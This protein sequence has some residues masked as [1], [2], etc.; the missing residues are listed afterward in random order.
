[1]HLWKLGLLAVVGG[2]SL[3]ER[4]ALPDWEIGNEDTDPVPPDTDIVDTDTG[5]VDT[6]TDVEDTD[7]NDT[8]VDPDA[9]GLTVP[10]NLGWPMR[11]RRMDPTTR[12]PL[13]EPCTVP[14]GTTS[15]TDASIE[16]VVDVNELDVVATGL[17]ID[18][19][20]PEG[21]CDYFVHEHY[22]YESWEVGDGPVEVSYTD[23]GDGTF[24]DEVNSVN[25]KPY[26]EYDYTESYPEYMDPP[27]CCLGGYTLTVTLPGGDVVV[28][29]GQWDGDAVECYAGAAFLDTEA[30]FDADG[31]PARVYTYIDENAS[32]K[33]F[34]FESSMMDYHT[35]VP[36]A[37]WYLPSQHDGSRPAPLAGLRSLP[38]YE[39]G[40]ADGAEEYAARIRYYVREWNELD[41]Y[42]IDGDPNTTG[43]ESPVSGPLDDWADWAVLG[44]GDDVFPFG[45]D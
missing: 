17:Q 1:M 9:F 6:D 4:A 22:Y 31:W 37:N 18:G 35:S 29:D 10:A 20:A 45:S 2:C 24:S 42:L 44:P 28:S 36:F 26:C 43:T 34:V 25:G 5:V 7:G 30:V 23:N 39:I 40:C 15:P 3:P 41:E 19:Y 13:N 16:C 38:Y 11:I 32:V 27:N 21:M 14:R 8:D 12:L 33:N